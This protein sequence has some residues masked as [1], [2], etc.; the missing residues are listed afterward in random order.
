MWKIATLIMTTAFSATLL[1]SGP[2]TLMVQA[3]ANYNRAHV[4]ANCQY[5]CPVTDNVT[6]VA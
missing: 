5:S 4:E 3:K 2:E 6:V 1:I